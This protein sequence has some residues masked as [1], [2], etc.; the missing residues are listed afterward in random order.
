MAH[1][2]KEKCIP[3]GLCFGSFSDVFFQ[4]SDGKAE[5]INNGTLTEEQQK[6]YNE[7]KPMCPVNAIE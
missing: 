4:W 2:D 5:V 1:I 3:C 6:T 7:V